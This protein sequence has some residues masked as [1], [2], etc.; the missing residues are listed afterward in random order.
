MRGS[1]H[2][3]MFVK[4]GTRLGTAT[5]NSGGIQGGISNG[6]HIVFRVAFKPPATIGKAQNTAN[7]EGE[8]DVMTAKG[9][10]DP[11]VVPRAVPIVEA[12]AALAMADAAMAQLARLGAAPLPLEGTASEPSLAQLN[13][14]LSRETRLREAYESRVTQLLEVLKIKPLFHP[15]RIA[16]LLLGISLGLALARLAYHRVNSR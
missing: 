1:E 16:P 12:M 2:N 6:E 3:D 4:K 5:N 15:E 13:K 14:D 8:P 9:R 7:F 10:H 11:C